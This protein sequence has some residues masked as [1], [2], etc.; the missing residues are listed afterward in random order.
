[1]TGQEQIDRIDQEIDAN[2]RALLSRIRFLPATAAEY[3]AAWDRNPDLWAREH[4]LFCQRGAAQVVRDEEINTAWRAEQR[5]IRH[6][7][8]LRSRAA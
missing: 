4:E 5:R 1:M 7:A 6:A 3:Q 8:K 2:R